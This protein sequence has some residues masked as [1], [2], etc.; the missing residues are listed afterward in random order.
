[1]LKFKT[2]SPEPPPA[3]TTIEQAI[4]SGRDELVV[5]AK[6]QVRQAG[7]ITGEGQIVAGMKGKAERSLYY[8][9]KYILALNREN[10]LDPHLHGWFCNFLQKTPPYR[11]MA[12]MPRGHLK[13]FRRDY[14]ET[15]QHRLASRLTDDW[16]VQPTTF[17]I[18]KDGERAEI[19]RL[20][21]RTGRAIEVS[22]NHPVMTWDGW[23]RADELTL[24]DWVAVPRVGVF[25]AWHNP[26][27]AAVYG[28]ML[29]DG[30]CVLMRFTAFN[31]ARRQHFIS[32]VVASGGEASEPPS[33]KQYVNVRKMRHI[34][35]SA[36]IYGKRAYN[37]SIPQEVLNG[38]KQTVT[39][40]LCALFDCDATDKSGRQGCA[41]T[42]ISR[43]LASDVQ[44]LLLKFGLNA[45]IQKVVHHTIGDYVSW[46]VQYTDDRGVWRQQTSQRH[47][48]DVFPPQWRSSIPRGAALRRV[49]VRVDNTYATSREKVRRAAEL[50]DD[51]DLLALCDSDVGWEPIKQ[52]ESLGEHEIVSVES[53]GTHTLLVGDIV[54]HNSTCV[55]EC[56][57]MH[58]LLQPREHN[59]YWPGM[60]G[61]E[62]RILL[63]G[64]KQELM[65]AHLRWIETQFTNN[66]LVRAF[67]SH[68][69]WENPKRDAK[70]W[71][72]IEMQLPR[73]ATN[74]YADP[75]IRVIGVGGAI[76][77]AHP[78]VLI[79]DD[80]ISIEAANS[81]VVMQTAI[82]YHISSRALL[83]PNEDRGLEFI[84][85]CLPGDAQVLL[86]DGTS[87][88]LFDV[89]VGDWVWSTD[90]DGQLATR[91]VEA[92][93][94]QGVA[95]TYTIQTVCR[96]L[97][98]TG[99]HP[100]LVRRYAEL[101]WTRADQLQPGD[102]V[103][104]MKSIPGRLIH[105][106]MTEEFFWFSGFLLGD[107][108]CGGDMKRGYVCIAESIYPELNARVC[109]I[110]TEW[111]PASPFY[112]TAFG[113]IRSDSTQAAQG[114]RDLG[115]DGRAKTKRIPLWVFQAPPDFRRAFLKGLCEADASQS[116]G[117]AD[118][119]QLELSNRELVEDVRALAT[120]C[121]VRVGALR[122]RFRVIQPP[123]SAAP[124]RSHYWAT[125]LNFD[126]VTRDEIYP[127]SRKKH[128][129][130]GLRQERVVAVIE[131]VIEEPVYD[132]TIAGTPAFFANGFAVHNT[133]WAVRD[134]YEHIQST[135]PTVAVKI[136]SIIENNEP[137]WKGKVTREYVDALRKE[138]GAMFYLLYM[139][140]A[141]DPE[142][143]DFHE[144]DFRYYQLE[145]DEVVFEED[146]RDVVLLERTQPRVEL[147]AP[148][149][150]IR[151]KILTDQLL[152]ELHELRRG[153]RFRS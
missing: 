76:T 61:S 104:V 139:N 71:N 4:D 68:R 81:P 36:G 34:F 42:T 43:Q 88:M 101:V 11:K 107:G 60:D 37:K 52:I 45:T 86:A 29:G 62:M 144:K 19:I 85:G 33:G 105:P 82:D 20:S 38:T 51:G 7:T 93:I 102:D 148:P 64:E 40:F 111:F 115:L 150:D 67:W 8:F 54:T 16:K 87:K 53:D 56:L 65:S 99:T 14:W 55:S 26:D 141:A 63:I 110:G 128:Y 151:G 35:K 138:Y 84:I 142:L 47:Q 108:W 44:H 46:C 100:F 59:V 32:C 12:L 97:R 149:P 134:L 3:P 83:A 132:L 118:S 120:L 80:L 31:A 79:K 121:G 140:S 143:T 9:W 145:G 112:S 133:R 50:L 137:I 72:A 57:P 41:Y 1:M 90:T 10:I 25:G 106:W 103:I 116:R 91:Q 126:T 5:D 94:F 18:A 109:R 24:H 96:T 48:W 13:C 58:I 30:D 69:L 153:W 119:W 77:G 135:D 6:G 123:H 98:A 23:K 66:K 92:K 136:R 127:K 147:E 89:C 146:G 2:T 130:T 22:V 17:R 78:N 113:Y 39:A 70:T 49:G 15:V 74:D 73:A 117:C 114:L 131:N 27:L 21:T 28:Y 124:V 129:A 122:T 125:F 75:S 152:G 95:K